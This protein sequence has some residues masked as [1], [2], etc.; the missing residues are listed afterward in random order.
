MPELELISAVMPGYVGGFMLDDFVILFWGFSNILEG[1][2][3]VY[4]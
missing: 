1:V 2:A 4:E 3:F